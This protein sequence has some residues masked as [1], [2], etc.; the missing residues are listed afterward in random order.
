VIDK[1]ANRVVYRFVIL[2][3]LALC[4]DEIRH[5]P[6]RQANRFPSVTFQGSQLSHSLRV[7]LGAGLEKLATLPEC[8]K[9]EQPWI[10]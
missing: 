2:R 8:A 3:E 6:L 10:F 4:G 7:S 5:F 9:I 1:E